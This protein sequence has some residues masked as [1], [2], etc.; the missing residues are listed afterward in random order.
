[1][2][3]WGRYDREHNPEGALLPQEI[4]EFTNSGVAAGIACVN[5]SRRSRSRSSTASTPAHSTYASFSYLKYGLMRL[6]SQIAQDSRHQGR[7]GALGRGPLRAGDG[8]GLAHPLRHL[9][10]RA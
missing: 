5:L 8:R 9:R 6:F 3:G 10:D 7:Q 1:M 2:K 4:T